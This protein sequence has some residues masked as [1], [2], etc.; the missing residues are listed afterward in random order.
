MSRRFRLFQKKRTRKNRTKASKKKFR[1]RQLQRLRLFI[2]GLCLISGLV[3]TSLLFVLGHDMVTQGNLFNAERIVVTG[4]NRLTKEEVLR[5]ANITPKMNIFSLNLNVVRKRL[6]SNGWVAEAKVR[7]ELPDGLVVDIKE[8]EPL[9]LLNLGR[10]YAISKTGVIFMEWTTSDTHGLFRV[11]GLDYSDILIESC[12]PSDSMDG[13]L[14]LIKVL[15]QNKNVMPI[16]NLLRIHVDRD[17]GLTL[18]TR[19][20]INRIAFG[21]K[22]YEQKFDRL[23]TLMDYL[24]HQEQI[25]AFDPIDLTNENY[26]VANP[27]WKVENASDNTIRRS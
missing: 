24:K 3:F 20:P 15:Q 2:Q 18:Y 8:N 6:L 14:D 4:N 26:I 12:R 27:V 11:T 21:F 19:G 9:A 16:Q 22:N 1:Q 5:V 17:L 7:R 13:F 10:E 25:C 23:C